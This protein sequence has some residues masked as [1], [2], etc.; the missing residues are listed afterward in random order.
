MKKYHKKTGENLFCQDF[1]MR[2]AISHG[3][4]FLGKLD[5]EVNFEQWYEK[6]IRVYKGQGTMGAPSYNPV[7]MFKMLFLAYLFNI[8][9]REIE[10]TVNDS[11]SMKVF[12]GLSFMDPAPDHSSLTNFKNRILAYGVYQNRDIFKEIFD[13]IILIAQEKGIDLGYT[14]IIDSTHTVADVNTR[15]EKKRTKPKDEGGEGKSKRDKDAKWGVKKIDKIKTLEG[16]TVKVKESYFGYKSHLSV[17]GESNLIT[18]YKT[19]PMNYP[20][21]HAF[22]PLLLDDI[23]KRVAISDKTNYSADRAYDDGELHAWLNKYRLK[24]SIFLKN[25]KPEEKIDE[26]RIKA[27]WTTYTSQEEFE[28]GKKERYAVERVNGGLKLHHGLEKARYLSL[29]KM[30]IQT[31]LTGI[32]HNLKT[33]VKLW[34]GVGLRTF[35][36]VPIMHA[37]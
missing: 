34:T 6:L 17:N 4:Q 19:T 18:S 22:I 30:N 31:A 3:N 7:Q 33:L 5:E 23:S 20:D 9:E 28:A 2:E 16:N 24:D 27:R 37:S 8:S 1:V 25:I 36:T 29:A 11:I 14:Q 12:L 10:R 13:E 15:K 35:S 21:N 26:K 32:A